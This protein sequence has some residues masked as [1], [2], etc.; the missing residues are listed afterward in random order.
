M[1]VTDE[2]RLMMNRLMIVGTEDVTHGTNPVG[3]LR[4][5]GSR[6]NRNQT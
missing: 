4:N 5:L 3:G 2:L 6:S 1:N